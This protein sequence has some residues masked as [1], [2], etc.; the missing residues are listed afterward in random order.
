[1]A[2][3]Q[4]ANP[5]VSNEVTPSPLDITPTVIVS[6]QPGD[7]TP[8]STNS[9]T[10]IT[11]GLE[12]LIEKAKEDL[13]QRLSISKDQI[14]LVETIEVEWSDSS[15]DCPQPDMLYL[16]VITPGY[17]ILLE[18]NE[19][20]YEYHSNRDAYVVYCDNSNLPALPKP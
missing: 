8:M 18:A 11:S 10:P 7:A 4:V 14:I 17:R 20:Q 6:P 5:N 12:S 2:C 9:P 16:Q 13:A 19:T 1:M 15:L 3:T